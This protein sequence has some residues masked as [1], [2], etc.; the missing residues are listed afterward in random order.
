MLK[1]SL[2]FLLL[3]VPLTLHAESFTIN[4]YNVNMEV[5]KD[6]RVKVSENILVDFDSSK[7]GIFRVIPYR[8]Y[9][10]GAWKEIRISQIRSKEPKKVTRKYG[11]VNIRFGKSDVWLPVGEKNYEFSYM[12]DKVMLTASTNYDELYWN[13]IGTKWEVPIYHTHVEIKFPEGVILKDNLQYRIYIG[14]EGSTKEYHDYEQEEWNG[15]PV[16]ETYDSLRESRFQTVESYAGV[17]QKIE[18]STLILD[19]A[20]T[21]QPYEGLTVQI[22][23]KKGFIKITTWQI[24]KDFLYEWYHL[25]FTGIL[26]LASLLIWAKWGK[27]EKVHV[28]V[29]YFPPDV[30]PSEA[31]SIMR[32]ASHFDMSATLVDLARRG[33]LTI[34]EEGKKKFVE[35]KKEPDSNLKSY[36]KKLM[37]KLFKAVY[38]DSQNNNRV[39]TDSLTDI[40]YSDFEV[41]KADFASVFDKKGYFKK[42]GNQWRG[43]YIFLIIA[44]LGLLFLALVYWESPKKLMLFLFLSIINNAIFAYIMPQKSEK[45]LNAYRQIL[46]F[47]EFILRA[48]QDKI[49]RLFN[50]NRKYF[51]ETIAYAMAFGLAG[52]WGRMFNNLMS[53]PPDWYQ[54]YSGTGAFRPSSFIYTLSSY[55]RTFQSA[56]TSTPSSSGSGSGSSSSWSGG[57]GSWGGSSGGGFGGGG[58]GSW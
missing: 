4:D 13:V 52:K 6:G 14:K 27:D 56:A 39:Y 58:G 41:I 21:L 24:I 23:L 40:F 7:R 18:G 57:G 47:K 3:F 43:F 37:E 44:A 19:Y 16:K 42:T 20:A 48:E 2:L 29:E 45:G 17:R 51:D 22:R 31:A 54:G 50:E 33:Y 5:F 35:K 53:Q 15:E 26:V 34:G 8:S 32:Q 28:M 9:V 36:E 1:K 10:N 49:M 25:I 38:T 30:S 55:T 46:G 12:V 11:E